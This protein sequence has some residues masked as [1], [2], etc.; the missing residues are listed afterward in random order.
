MWLAP[1]GLAGRWFPIGAST[2]VRIVTDS[3]LFSGGDGYAVLEHGTS[4]QSPSHDVLQ[5]TVDYIGARSPVG[6]V[7]EGRIVGP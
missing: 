5:V 2:P 4:V 7:V 1:S 6:S 3:F